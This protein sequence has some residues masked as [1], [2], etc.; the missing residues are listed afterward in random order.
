[1]NI[2]SNTHEAIISRDMFNAVQN[3]MKQR[4]MFILLLL[5]SHFPIC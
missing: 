4:K 1:M 2:I 5:N 3:Q